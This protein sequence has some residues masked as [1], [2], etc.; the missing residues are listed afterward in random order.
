[1]TQIAAVNETALVVFAIV[2]GVTM[3]VTYIDS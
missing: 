2:V 3:V 1:M